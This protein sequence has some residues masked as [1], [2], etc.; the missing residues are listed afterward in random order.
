M[1]RSDRQKIQ[2]QKTS[3]GMAEELVHVVSNTLSRRLYERFAEALE[4][5]HPEVFNYM[6]ICLCAQQIHS[7]STT[8]NE[9]TT[10]A[11]SEMDKVTEL[12]KKAAAKSP[13]N[14]DMK[15]NAIETNSGLLSSGID[16]EKMLKKLLPYFSRQNKLQITEKITDA[17]KAR[18]LISV[19]S[20]NL[21]P[22]LYDVFLGGLREFHHDLYYYMKAYSTAQ[23]TYG[24]G[25]ARKDSM[26]DASALLNIKPI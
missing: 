20:N 24:S 22:H 4:E 10:S 23:D 3:L 1:T 12:P 13:G 5:Y 11:I 15:R 17:E 8:E 19:L 9:E 16:V 18:E 2:S 21:T 14:I 6:K 7:S 26:A 25:N